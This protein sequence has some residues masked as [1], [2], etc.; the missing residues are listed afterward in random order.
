MKIKMGFVD[1][2]WGTIETDGD[3]FK[4][5]GAEVVTLQGLV[6]EYQEWNPDASPTELLR[7]ILDSPRSYVW[8]SEVPEQIE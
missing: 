8:A 6:T 5:D 7:I 1:E 2:T 3:A 4:F